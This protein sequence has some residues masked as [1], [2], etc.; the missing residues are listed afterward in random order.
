[1]AGYSH[2]DIARILKAILELRVC[3]QPGREADARQ[4]SHI[5]AFGCHG[6]ELVELE[7]A[8]QFDVATRARKLDSERGAPGAGPDNSYSC[9][10]VVAN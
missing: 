1:M 9:W 4:V 6:L 10:S 7:Q 8:A 5:F 2:Q 3:R